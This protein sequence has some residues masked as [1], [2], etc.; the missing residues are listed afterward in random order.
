[1]VMAYVLMNLD[2]DEGAGLFRS[3][4]EIEEVKEVHS[5]FGVYDVVVRLEAEDQKDLEKLII[6]KIRKLP[7]VRQTITNWVHL[8]YKR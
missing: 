6:W 2:P 7:G 8:G 1:V 3:L 4:R 5:L